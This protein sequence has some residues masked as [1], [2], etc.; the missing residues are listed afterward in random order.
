M[1]KKEPFTRRTLIIILEQALRI[2]T[3]EEKLSMANT[4][5]TSQDGT[6]Y[7]DTKD[8]YFKNNVVVNEP[9]NH[10]TTDSLLYN[11]RTQASNYVGNTHI[12]N[13]EVDIYTT[14]G[15]YDF[16]TGN[17]LFTSRTT[18]RDSS[19]RVYIANNMALDNKSGNAQLEGN[20]IVKDSAGGYIVFAN[21]IFL[22]KTSNSF[23]ATRKPVLIIKQKD[24]SIYVAA[25]TIFSGYSTE[26]KNEDFINQNKSV[27]NDSLHKKMMV[28][29]LQK[30]DTSKKIPSHKLK[31]EQDS[32]YN[33]AH[34]IDSLNAVKENE[35]SKNYESLNDS[36]HLSAPHKD[37]TRSD[38]VRHIPPLKV[39]NNT[40]TS[41]DVFHRTDSLNTHKTD[42][43]NAAKRNASVSK[44]S[45]AKPDSSLI[46]PLREDSTKADSIHS[47]NKKNTAK[48]RITIPKKIQPMQPIL[49]GISSHFIA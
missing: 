25:D 46:S 29:T 44:N 7:A 27:S 22:N 14:Q 9:K 3:M 42:S 47:T 30:A 6:Y 26:V 13:K 45:F 43:L 49:R 24:D 41:N 10:I 31:N 8:I 40:D 36:S 35:K 19:K 12:N 20:A 38:S 16:N 2:I 48:A 21:Q 23:L 11:L 37:S 32:S 17:A 1:I 28:D 4:T 33:L 34:E 15:T 39:K 18:V 5:I